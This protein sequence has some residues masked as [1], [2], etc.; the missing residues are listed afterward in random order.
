[1]KRVF[2]ILAV[3]AVVGLSSCSTCYECTYEVEIQSPNGQVTTETEVEP[4]C[5]SDPAEIDAREAEG[6]VCAR[7][8]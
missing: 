3:A 6:Q 2:Q 4:I 5:T 8:A 7:T 1:M